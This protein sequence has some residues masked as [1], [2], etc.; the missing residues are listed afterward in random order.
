MPFGKKKAKKKA[1]RPLPKAM[2]AVQVAANEV[3]KLLRAIRKEGKLSVDL[4]MSPPGFDI[5][6]P[7]D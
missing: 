7:K 6:L 3:T 2:N 4:R 5:R 1:K